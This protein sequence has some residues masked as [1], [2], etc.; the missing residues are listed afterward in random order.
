MITEYTIQAADNGM[1]ISGEEMVLAIENTH[2]INGTGYDNLIHELGK[3]FYGDILNAMNGMIANNVKVKI[4]IT[5][6][7]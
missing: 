6:E 7:D 5:K 3:L 2:I 1:L 4:E